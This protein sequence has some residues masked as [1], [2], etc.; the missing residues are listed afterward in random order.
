M[1]DK[2]AELNRHNPSVESVVSR[3]DRYEKKIKHITAVV[4]WED[5]SS[6]VVH[7]TKDVSI[8]CY[9]LKILDSHIDGFISDS[10][11]DLP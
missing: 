1:I 6:D 10:S 11:E 8:L 9:E 4:E 7:D 3:L 5:G 2:V